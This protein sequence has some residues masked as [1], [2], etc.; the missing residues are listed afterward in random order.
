MVRLPQGAWAPSSLGSCEIACPCQLDGGSVRARLEQPLRPGSDMPPCFSL[1]VESMV[2]CQV[3]GIPSSELR[4]PTDVGAREPA[5]GL[6]TGRGY[7]KIEQTPC[8]WVRP[9]GDGT[10]GMSGWQPQYSR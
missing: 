9:Q 1:C 4:L 5:W 8:G 7:G 2:S 3:I 10:T 6:I